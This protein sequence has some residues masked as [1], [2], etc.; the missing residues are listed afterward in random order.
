MIS[1]SFLCTQMATLAAYFNLGQQKHRSLDDVRMNLEVLKHCATVL[2]LV[3]NK[4]I[5]NTCINICYRHFT[6]TYKYTY[7]ES[8]LPS[9][10]NANYQ[11]QASPTMMTRSRTNAL[12]RNKEETSRKSPSSSI[13]RPF[14]YAAGNLGKVQLTSNSVLF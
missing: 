2:F 6:N 8:S 4:N 11:T 12:V 10:A 7:Q 3:C 13:H 5:H 9:L 14:P 1:C